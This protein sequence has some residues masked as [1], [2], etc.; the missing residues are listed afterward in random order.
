VRLPEGKTAGSLSE[1][2]LLETYWRATK[3]DI[4]DDRI[5]ALNELAKSIM[6]DVNTQSEPHQTSSSE[7]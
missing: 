1:I 2:E 6:D 4:E 5:Q 7:A 3:S